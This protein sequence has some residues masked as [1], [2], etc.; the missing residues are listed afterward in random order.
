MGHSLEMYDH[1]LFTGSWCSGSPTAS[2]GVVHCHA[3]RL[4][5]ALAPVLV[6]GVLL[7]VVRV[8]NLAW[9]G[10][11]L[12][13]KEPVTASSTGNDDYYPWQFVKH[14]VFLQHKLSSRTPVVD[15]TKCLSRQAVVLRVKMQFP[16]LTMQEGQ[17]GLQRMARSLAQMWSLAHQSRG[18]LQGM[19]QVLLFGP[20]WVVV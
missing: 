16:C 5:V 12:G 19:Q 20:Q 17:A 15:S 6:E 2:E 4:A 3:A 14:D 11:A 8:I 18:G 9:L 7:L 13:L 1:S 10:T